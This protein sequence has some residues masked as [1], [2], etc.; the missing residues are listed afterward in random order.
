MT[1]PVTD[2]TLCRQLRRAHDYC[3][4]HTLLSLVQ[5]SPELTIGNV[6]IDKAK[7]LHLGSREG[8]LLRQLCMHVKTPVL[9]A[10]IGKLAQVDTMR[11][12]SP[13]AQACFTNW[14]TL[15]VGSPATATATTTPPAVVVAQP[16]L[17]E[18]PDALQQ[19]LH[20]LVLGWWVRFTI[21]HKGLGYYLR[22]GWS[23]DVDPVTLDDV[24]TELP[25]A[26]TM[27]TYEFEVKRR[28]CWVRRRTGP[29]KG[30]W[31]AE[32][33]A[34][35]PKPTKTPKVFVFDV[36]TLAEL[37]RKKQWKS[38]F[39]NREFDKATVKQVARR[40]CY[41]TQR[42]YLQPPKPAQPSHTAAEAASSMSNVTMPVRASRPAPK[43]RAVSL[44]SE[45]DRLN[46]PVCV[47]WLTDLRR[48]E[49]I[50]WYQRCEDIWTYR[51]QLSPAQQARIAP[52]GRRVFYARN[53]IRHVASLNE[54]Q[55]LMLD[56]MERLVTT[57]HTEADRTNGLMYVLM[58]LT[59]VSTPIRET[60]GYLYQPDETSQ[61]NLNA[62][63]ATANT[64]D[65][66]TQAART[67]FVQ[68][69]VTEMSTT[70]PTT[71]TAA[72]EPLARLAVFHPE[73]SRPVP[74]VVMQHI[75]A[76]AANDALPTNTVVW[77][78]ENYADE[79]FGA[80]IAQAVR[81]TLAGNSQGAA[82]APTTGASAPSVSAA[83]AGPA[84]VG[85]TQSDPIVV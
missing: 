81:A 13:A 51:A 1:T 80:D 6:P 76:L 55:H 82:T 46:F 50:R 35:G 30:E 10:L 24:R 52:G 14:C 69:I 64:N 4:K 22:S 37:F 11:Q 33:K 36:R 19:R 49:I 78:M 20:A 32:F 43:V 12:Q 42:G 39:D 61:N 48:T 21:R 56:A 72:L 60:Y 31:V 58:A 29:L 54:M 85:G 34:V 25:S 8:K 5:W 67:A 74:T 75:A 27:T 40:I 23:N 71:V 63:N 83:G 28:K 73:L 62:T 16:G 38:P 70:N 66:A 53:R 44:C 79:T 15:H 26:F 41:L 65:S 17:Q 47:E 7:D 2:A 59:E 9:K 57:G 68:A 3:T 18:L 77:A 84:G 45:M